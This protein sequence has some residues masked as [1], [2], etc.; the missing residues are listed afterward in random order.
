MIYEMCLDELP[1][2]S[3]GAGHTPGAGGALS[4]TW[5]AAYSG[6]LPSGAGAGALSSSEGM[7]RH[8][9]TPAR[10]SAVAKLDMAHSCLSNSAHHRACR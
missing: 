1:Q 5:A 4:T 6:L 3:A 8:R 2:P 7:L 9:E 10:V